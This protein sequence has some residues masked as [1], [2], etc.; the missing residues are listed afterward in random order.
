MAKNGMN[1]VWVNVRPDDRM[2]PTA[3]FDPE[4]G[5]R[6][7]GEPVLDRCLAEAHALAAGERERRNVAGLA[8]AAAYWKAA[9]RYF[10]AYHAGLLPAPWTD[11]AERRTACR[12]MREAARDAVQA[13]QDAPDSGWF[14]RGLDR[15][16]KR[17]LARAEQALA[18]NGR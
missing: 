8:Q 4:T 1:T 6:R 18:D 9:A 15:D 16:W 7:G 13:I 11:P 2:D 12:R 10:K 14:Y 17:M 3:V 5:E